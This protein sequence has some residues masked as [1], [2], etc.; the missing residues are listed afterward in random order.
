M[1]SVAF[2]PR[3]I[4]EILDTSFQILRRHY[5]QFVVIAGCL[6][7][8]FIA[9]QFLVEASLSDPSS[10]LLA[11]VAGVFFLLF[12]FVYIV[13]SAVAEAAILVA[14]SDAYR[15]HEVR[16]S[17]ALR[18]VMA[19]FGPI[20]FASFNKAIRVALWSLLL[21]IPGIIAYVRYFA[22]PATVVLEGRSGSDAM[23]R[24]RA[25]SEGVKGRVFLAL[26]AVWMIW[27]ALYFS[28]VAVAALV[29]QSERVANVAGAVF[30]IFTY[31]LIP[32]ATALLYYDVRIRKEGYDIELMAQ[33]L[34]TAS[35]PAEQP[36]Y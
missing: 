34:S 11:G 27:G 1:S 16:A 33:E 15:G 18:G 32:I 20:L 9:V 6:Y 36:A 2:R 19:R 4:P 5:G 7:L 3:S 8:P 22:I 17:D 23:A 26:L 25:L 24:A 30:S 13:W 12:M 10:A 28:I 14:A 35:R 29:S 21:I 31:P